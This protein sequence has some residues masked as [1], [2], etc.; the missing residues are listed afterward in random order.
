MISHISSRRTEL[1]QR[2][3]DEHY[4]DEAWSASDIVGRSFDDSLEF[5]YWEF[6]GDQRIPPQS[7][8]FLEI[9]VIVDG[10][11]VFSCDGQI[12]RLEVGDI[13]V[14]EGPTGHQRMWS[15]GL[16][17]AYFQRPRQITSL[18]S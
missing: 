9:F 10:S 8:D 14:V 11:G 18:E 7:D 2:L 6:Q 5:G 1:T 17:A 15:A 16:K 4:L 12:L 3:P 13:L